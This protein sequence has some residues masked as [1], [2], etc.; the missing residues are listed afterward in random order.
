MV[1]GW[2]WESELGELFDTL[3]DDGIVTGLLIGELLGGVFETR[4]DG[5]VPGIWI[6]GRL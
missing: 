4:D 5:V 3:G 6:T 1:G 2:G